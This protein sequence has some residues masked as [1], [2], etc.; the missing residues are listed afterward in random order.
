MSGTAQAQ[1]NLNHP[2]STAQ[3]SGAAISRSL[4]SKL[5]EH[6]SV[7]DFAY[8]TT[9]GKI[10]AGGDDTPAFSAAL[11]AATA[12]AVIYVPPG[13]YSLTGYPGNKAGVSW[14]LDNVYFTS[15]GIA[16]AIDQSVGQNVGG[17]GSGLMRVLAQPNGQEGQYYAITGANTGSTAAYQKN[18]IHVRLSQNDVSLYSF[19]GD[20][21]TAPHDLVGYSVQAEC[22]ASNPKCSLF[23]ANWIL[24][25]D[26]GSD[27]PATT[28]EVQIIDNRASGAA[29]M[30]SWDNIGA[31]DY[32]FSG[33]SPST[34]GLTFQGNANGGGFGVYDGIVFRQGSVG[35]KLLVQRAAGT[36]GSNGIVPGGHVDTLWLGADGSV[37]GQTLHI[38]GGSATQDVLP[39]N[40]L[41]VDANGNILTTGD[42]KGATLHGTGFAVTGDPNGSVDLGSQAANSGTTPYQDFDQGTVGGV[43]QYC[44][45]EGAGGANFDIFCNGTNDAIFYPGGVAFQVVPSMPA[46]TV[47]GGKIALDSSGT[48]WVQETGG[49]VVI[50]TGS[51]NLFSINTSSGNVIAKGTVTQS[52]AP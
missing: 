21:T 2:G 50:G 48:V 9:T 18:A 36:R 16:E 3:V 39:S 33:A 14:Q 46:V 31:V 34:N 25:L 30:D 20:P 10:G 11:A 7:A 40:G 51:T 27:G 19:L 47:N 32:I 6:T 49:K 42:V 43:R 45:V 38:G 22:P 15:G 1:F 13:V 26:A 5:S 44:R 37:F 12:P 35:K 4:N 17:V 41:A 29:E 23:G 24:Q 28:N 52:G 8:T